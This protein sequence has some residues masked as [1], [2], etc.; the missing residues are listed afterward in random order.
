MH[1]ANFEETLDQ[2]LARCA[3]RATAAAGTLFVR[4]ALDFTQK[5]PFAS[6]ANAYRHR[7]GTLTPAF[8][9]TPITWSAP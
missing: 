6:I 2:I 3:I 4:D 9:I 8:A 1:E 7:P 5:A